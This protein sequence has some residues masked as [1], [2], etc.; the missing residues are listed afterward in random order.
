MKGK[1]IWFK[2]KLYGWGWNPITWQGWLATLVYCV[3]IVT[4][5]TFVDFND[6]SMSDTLLRFVVPFAIF[7]G[8]F[9]MLCY[10]KGERPR[11]RWGK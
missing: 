5:F 2:A 11:W 1:E 6:R 4:F 10:T 8:L 3:G 9:I 7:T